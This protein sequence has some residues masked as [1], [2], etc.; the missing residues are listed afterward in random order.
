MGNIYINPETEKRLEFVAEAE[1]RTKTGEIDFL[2]AERI[3]ELN[4]ITQ[5][6]WKSQDGKAIED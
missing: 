5:E 1:K 3:K 4:L 2:V 6:N